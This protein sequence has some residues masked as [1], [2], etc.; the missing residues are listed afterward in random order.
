MR[1]SFFKRSLSF[2]IDINVI[3][4]I[5]YVL[6]LLFINS[7]IKGGIPNVDKYIELQ[8]KQLERTAQL[9][10]EIDEQLREGIITEDEHQYKFD[11]YSENSNT[12]ARTYLPTILVYYLN[13]GLYFFGSF[14]LLN[15]FYNLILDGN[16][17]GRRL[18]KLR[19]EGRI[20]W[21]SLLNRELLYKGCF[22]LLTLPID[23]YLIKFSKKKKALRDLATGI[24]VIDESAKYPF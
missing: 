1:A 11:L 12:L 13:V 3:Y 5:L 23:F 2:L 22:G 20:N 8:E 19:L 17:I 18:L 16:T 7:L 4:I 9:Y 6:F 21:F 15:Y 10:D 14:V 24:Y